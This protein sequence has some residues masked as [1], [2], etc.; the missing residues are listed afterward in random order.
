MSLRRLLTASRRALVGTGVLLAACSGALANWT[1]SGTIQ[2]RD[3]LY[4]QTGFTGVE[5]AVAARFVDVEVVDATSSSVIGSGA[6]TATGTFSFTVTD[7]STRNIFLRAKTSSTK[8]SDLFLKVTMSN[9]STVYSIVS[10]TING[11]TSTTNVNFGTLVAGIGAGGEAFNLYDMGV[12]GADFLAFLNGARPSSSHPLNIVW[13]IDG[14]NGGSSTT[15]TTILMRDSGGYDDSVLLHEYGHYAVFAYSATS[16]PGGT[17]ALADCAQ[18]AR[19]AWEEGHAS[20]FGGRIQNHFGMPHPNVYMRSDGGAG[21]GHM[22]LWFDLETES[23]YSCSGDTS[24]VSVYTALWDITDSAATADFTPG[25]DDAPVDTLAM[26]DADHWNVMKN[27]LPS[28]SYITAE[29]YWDSWFAPLALGH[30]PE[31]K[32]IFEGVEIRFYEDAYE[33]NE[34]QSAAK[35]VPADG[36]LIHLTLFR[37]PDGDHSGGGTSDVDWF[38]FPAVNGLQYTLETT[39]LLSACDTSLALFNAAGSQL[40]SNDNRGSGDKSSLI[41][42]TATATGTFY[43]RVTRVGSQIQ[44]GSYDLKITPPPDED[45]DGVPDASDN[46]PTVANP[47]Q[48]DTDADGKGDACDNCPAV[49]NANQADADSDGRGDACDNCPAVANA[50]QTDTDGDGKG[51]AC[52][53]CPTLANAT[54]IDGDSDGRGDACDNCPTIANASQTDTDGDG[55]GDACDNCPTVANTTQIDGDSDGKGDACDDCPA[56]ANPTQADADSDGVGDACDDCPAVPNPGQEDADADGRGD[57]CDNCPAT[58]NPSQ[59]DADADGKGDACDPCPH[60]AANDADGDGVCGDVDNCPTVPNPSQ[61]DLDRDGLGDACDSDRDGDSVPNSVDCAP[62]V[63]ET[64]ATPD[65]VADVKFDGNKSTLRWSGARQAHV[66]GVFRGVVS[67]GSAFSYDETCLLAA[68]TVREGADPDV[69]APGELYFYLVAG[70]NSCG[71]GGLGV[72][73]GGPRSVAQI[74]SSDPAVDTDGDGTS[75]LDDDCPA[76]ADPAQIDTDGD[77][78]GDACD[79]CPTGADPDQADADGDGLTTGCDPCPHDPLND[80]DGDGVCGDVDNCPTIANPT[81]ADADGDHLGDA[82]DAC[83]GDAAND[84]DRDG[85]CGDV[86]N[87]PTVANADQADADGD[88]IGDACDACPNDPANDADGDG[89]CGN[90]DNCPTVPNAGQADGDGD[91]IGDACDNCP[92][93]PLNDVDG[94]GVCGNVDNCPTVAN[95]T[96]ADGDGDGRGDACDNC[97]AVANPSQADS[98]ADGVGDVCDNCPSIAN[99]A[100]TNTDGDLLGD[101]CDA[102]PADPL[103]DID[104]DGVCGNVDNCPAVANPSQ[105]DSDADGVG[106][107]CDNC[108]L[109]ANAGQQDANG[110]GVGDA[111]AVARANAWTTGLTH[112]AGTGVNRLL[113]FMVGYEN[114]ADV[115][116]S[117]V[118][119]G[120]QSLTRINGTVAGTTTVGRIELWYLNESG[121][122]AATST[123]FVVTYGGTAPSEPHYGAATFRNVDQTAPVLVSNVASAA[124]A[125]PNPLPVSV[126]VTADGEAVAAA[127]CGNPGSFT[128]ANGWT[129][130]FDQSLSSSDSSTA[131][132]ASV[133]NGTD[134]A[135]ATHSNQNRQAIVAAS[136]SVA[137]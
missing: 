55:K 119:Y 121:I 132:H 59:A 89:V 76:V 42:W 9:Q 49:A 69:P 28:R 118:T 17:H 47:S 27:G 46:C 126:N 34:T 90:L 12:Y 120:G 29:D 57:L 79:A 115:P 93:D 95:P 22:V 32:S 66:Y 136:L 108:R 103:N 41:T 75:D 63:R 94:D 67:P 52:D 65:E 72:G 83:P 58:A 26:T 106:N 71:E 31:M 98:D 137:H 111:C 134:T 10:S 36:S 14:G 43:L 112:V 81:Q 135:S 130:G 128:W 64:S 18:D 101:A 87:C 116:I 37:D 1:A 124:A 107:A 123:T 131:D 88:G 117:A 7:S 54:Q 127:F 129:T 50:S 105:A 60:D 39:N 70:R 91:G 40:A 84:V 13:Q 97:P 51:D 44:Y 110:N 48:T 23:Q 2:Y 77:G 33:P 21:P 102:C 8:T 61:A 35:A 45:G 3:R 30:F 4:D 133:A 68:A 85:V 109:V 6:T 78:V 99:P 74:C 19:L 96:Q 122:A 100:Q 53:N 92:A 80:V 11:H 62:D 73:T 56:V 15:A 16:S 24:E 114:G 125:T 104:G 38:S 113:V 5:P 86:D 25:V 82:C 20:Y